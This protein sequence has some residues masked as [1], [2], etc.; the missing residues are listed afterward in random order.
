M[1]HGLSPAKVINARKRPDA[2]KRDGAGF[3]EIEC[4][5][6]KELPLAVGMASA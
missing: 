2:S 5:G 4:C 3:D 6:M 1:L